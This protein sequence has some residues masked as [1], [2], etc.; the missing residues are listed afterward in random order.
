MLSEYFVFKTKT[1][2]F[3]QR[4][5]KILKEL[6]NNNNK[7]IIYGFGAGFRE[8]YS[9]F[10]LSQLNIC[11]IADIN[12][13][14]R[15]TFEN[16]PTIH[17]E[18]IKQFDFDSIL[19]TNESYESILH[20]LRNDLAIE[21][22]KIVTVFK[23]NVTDENKN[24]KYLVKYNFEKNL[25]KLK[26]KLKSKKIV[27]YGAGALFELMYKYFNLQELNI[28][29]VADIKYDLHDENEKFLNIK[30]ISPLE[31]ADLK[32]EYV[33]VATKNYI[34]IVN[35]LC[36]YLLKNTGIKVGLFIKKPF[37]DTLKDIWKS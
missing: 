26:N 31:I 6:K 35:D 21:D 9:K 4:L 27:V 1:D 37:I 2:D 12:N 29:A 24:Y 20:Y 25:T 19:I 30:A 16:I 14:K 33:L 13:I 3:N 32:P 15:G 10:G 17:P 28:I 11:A 23:E 5:D 8:L 36:Y 22:K 34:N 18:E 7:V